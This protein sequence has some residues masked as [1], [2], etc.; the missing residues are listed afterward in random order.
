MIEEE[1]EEEEEEGE[2]GTLGNIRLDITME[3]KRNYGVP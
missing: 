3:R 1:E 2:L